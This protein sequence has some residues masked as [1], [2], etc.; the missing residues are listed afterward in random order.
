MRLLIVVSLFILLAGDYGSIIEQVTRVF[1]TS[2]DASSTKES[3]SSS[4]GGDK[5]TTS[6]SPADVDDGSVEIIGKSSAFC[7]NVYVNLLW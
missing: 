6:S 3:T 5:T 4:K 7:M 2:G 1:Y